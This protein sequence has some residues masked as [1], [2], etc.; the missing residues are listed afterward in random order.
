MSR[1]RYQ[2]PNVRTINAKSHHKPSAK[3][4]IVK[5]SNAALD[6]VEK[7]STEIA[8]ALCL[9]AVGGN[10][11]STRLLVELAEGPAWIE[12]P[13]AVGR[14]LSVVQQWKSDAEPSAKRGKLL[15]MAA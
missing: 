8:E 7:H 3:A 12:D 11:S 5:L 10:A 9:A 1:T 15:Q 2:R 13:E 6:E 14:V 4:G